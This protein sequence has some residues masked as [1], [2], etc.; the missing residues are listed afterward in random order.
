M[1]DQ[2]PDVPAPA[3]AAVTERL[4]VDHVGL[5]HHLARRFTGRGE[6]Y[7]DLVQVASLALVKAA[8]RF[9]PTRGVEFATYATRTIIG[10]LK[11]H[12]RDAGWSVKTPRA[13]QELYLLVN[14]TVDELTERLQRSPTIAEVAAACGRRDDEVLTAMEAGRNYR[15]V[16]MAPTEEE[17][18]MART[19][20]QRVE[21]AS[22]LATLLR[23]LPDRE[24]VVVQMRFVDEL[25]QDQTAAALGISQMHVS[26]L[27]RNALDRMRSTAR[28]RNVDPETPP[29]AP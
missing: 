26:R 6:D 14:R 16:S 12:L 2:R 21:D 27:L 7:E 8:D 13:V 4:I 29:D 11:H 18:R 3:R 19:V 5:A 15:T 25:H 17:P 28:A 1:S 20:G 23:G 24:R 22:E 10:E 9:D